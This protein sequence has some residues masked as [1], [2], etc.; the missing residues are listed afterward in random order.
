[1]KN[2]LTGLAPTDAEVATAATGVAGFKTLVTSWTGDAQF[3]PLFQ[4]K[5][6]SLF[7]NVFQQTG[8]SPLDDFKPQ[9]L[10]NGGFD[11]GPLGTSVVGDDAFARLVQNLKDSFAMTAW[12]MV[13]SKQ[14]F[15]NVLTTNTVMMTTALKSLYLMIEMPNDQPFAFGA[16]G[17]RCTTDANCTKPFGCNTGSN[18]GRTGG[19]S[20]TCQLAWKVDFNA[21]VNT[22]AIPLTDTLNPS[23]PN[24]MVFDDA[25]PAAGRTSFNVGMGFMNCAGT[26]VVNQYYGYSQLFQRLFGNTAR[27]PF[28]GMGPACL[29]HASKPIYTTSDLTDWMPVT[30]TAKAAS[31]AYIQPYDLPTLRNTTTLPLAIP[32]IGYYTTPAFLALWNTNDS[33]QHRVTAN[34]TLMV[35]TGQ[36]LTPANS[37]MPLSEPGLDPSHAVT[38]TDCYGCHKSL[39]P[40]RQ[41]WATQLDFN[42][43]NDFPANGVFMGGSANPRPATTGGLLAFGNVNATGADMTALGPLLLQ[44]QDSGGGSISRFA[45]AMTQQLC[46]YA[47]SSPCLES[48]PEMRR[49]ATAFQS[50]NYNFITLITELFSSPLVTE[51]ADTPTADSVGVVISIL[52]RDHLCASLSNRLG[53]ADVCAQAV[54][55]PSSAQTATQKIVA[56]VAA[57]AFSRG[58]E[59]PVTP[60]DPTLFY[61][62]ASEMLCENVAVKAVDATGG[63]YSSSNVSAAIAA[64]VTNILGYPPSDSHNAMAATILQTHYNNAT[65]RTM[66]NATATNAL[67]STFALAC[68]SPT[69]LALG[70]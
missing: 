51:Q 52:R 56:S 4:G 64:M 12:S 17:T 69:L 30:V 55:L 38:G 32:R 13:A 58:S 36:S 48:D 37:I 57:D 35:A 66:G 59:I 31:A 28:V 62:A 8:F 20:G 10:Q 63:P 7:R 60:S 29:E 22:P 45:M 27:N 18:I 15:S 50:D 70:I 24:Y 68:L 40:L 3:A 9:L 53:I 49:V 46:Y 65:D 6:I 42:D 67:R 25:P 23:S 14:P 54:P 43:R 5:M 61:R 34:Q 11:L 33:N 21:G 39:D 1:V 16:G 2:L 44:V 41:F 47:N 19:T 26:A